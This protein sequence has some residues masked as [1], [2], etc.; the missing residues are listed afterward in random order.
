M[1]RTKG[2]REVCTE[3]RNIISDLTAAVV[4]QK[5]IEQYYSMPQ[6]SVS[7]II[8]K[9]EDNS[10]NNEIETRSRKKKL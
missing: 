1:G 9:L 3:R 4:R 2:E 8:I 5:Q 10:R 6:S 7:N